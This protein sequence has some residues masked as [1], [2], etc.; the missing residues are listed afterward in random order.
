MVLKMGVAEAGVDWLT[1]KYRIALDGYGFRLVPAWSDD[2]GDIE[3]ELNAAY[4]ELHDIYDEQI[5]TF[6]DG[7]AVDR[8]WHDVLRF[9]IERGR[10]GL[11]PDY[12]EEELLS[13]LTEVT[14]RLVASGDLA[15]FVDVVGKD[16]TLVFRLAAPD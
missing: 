11:Y 15:L 4:G 2:P 1:V 7:T 13:Q 14:E 8:A 12:P 6:S 16:D 10:F 9:E 3:A 5:S